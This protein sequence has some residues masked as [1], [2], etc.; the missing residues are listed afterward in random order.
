MSRVFNLSRCLSL[1]VSGMSSE[2]NLKALPGTT[3]ANSC[4]GQGFLFELC[5]QPLISRARTSR[6]LESGPWASNRRTL[7]RVITRYGTSEGANQEFGDCHSHHTLPTQ[8]HRTLFST[9]QKRQAWEGG[10]QSGKGS[11]GPPPTRLPL[12][13]PFRAGVTRQEGLPALGHTRWSNLGRRRV[14]APGSSPGFWT[15]KTERVPPG[16]GASCHRTSAEDASGSAPSFYCRS[17]RRGAG[18]GEAGSRGSE[19]ARVPRSCGLPGPRAPRGCAPRRCLP[20][21]PRPSR[22]PPA[23]PFAGFPTGRPGGRVRGGSCRGWR[24]APLRQVQRLGSHPGSAGPRLQISGPGHPRPL[25]LGTPCSWRREQRAKE[26]LS[27][28]RGQQRRTCWA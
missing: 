9:P 25:A 19:R 23:E 4:L 14:G 22:R 7:L 20:I 10:D 8:Y 5:G 26:C 2:C 16:G 28:A 13:C 18:Y 1:R 6:G 3:V 21:E 17:E 27:G 24:P 12:V 11:E 15:T